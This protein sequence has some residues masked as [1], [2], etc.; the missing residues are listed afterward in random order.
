[1]M[2]MQQLVYQVDLQN[3][4]NNAICLEN[5]SFYTVTWFLDNGD[6]EFNE[7]DTEITEGV[8]IEEDNLPAITGGDNIPDTF[9]ID[10]LSPG[11]IFAQIQDCIAPGCGIIVEFDLRPEPEPITLDMVID[12]TD[13]AL[14]EEASACIQINGGTP[15]YSFDISMT[16]PIEYDVSYALDENGCITTPDLQPGSY[17]I[18]ATDVNDCPSEPINFDFDIDL[19]NLIEPALIEV[20]ILVYQN[21]LMF[22]ASVQVMELFKA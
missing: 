21:G 8:F 11:S 6:T 4:F 2:H 7:F 20:D 16:E 5:Q 1:M 17:T 10:E 19:V 13:C 3:D 14:N 22:H 9:T 12:Q 15:P 18:S